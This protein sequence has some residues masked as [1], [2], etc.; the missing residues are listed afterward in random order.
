VA[1]KRGA[2]GALAGRG[3]ERVS[4]PGFAVEAIDTTGAG[5]A[6]DAGF[7]AGLLAGE[8]LAACVRRGNACGALTTLHIGGSGGFD[9]ARVEALLSSA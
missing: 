4:A 8:G 5:D 1:I 6:F 7:L 3:S 2:A 9:R